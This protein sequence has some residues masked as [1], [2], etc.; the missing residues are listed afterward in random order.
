MSRGID[1]LVERQVLRWLEEQRVS[2]RP[3]EP[4][5]VEASRPVICVSREFGS[6][7]GELG[8]IVAERLEF[9]FYGQELVDEIAR[10]AHVR[11]KVVESLDER[12]QSGIRQWVDQLMVVRRFAQSDYLR[13]LSQVV[14]T[15]GRHGRS[16]VIGRGAHLILDPASTLRVRC[17]APADWRIG[18]VAVRHN[19]GRSD[20]QA[21]MERVDAERAAFYRATFNADVSDPEHFDLLMNVSTTSLETCAEIVAQAFV[22][23]FANVS[24]PPKSQ[25]RATALAAEPAAA[26]RG[27]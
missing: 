17:Y 24:A 6:L 8:R 2:L 27:R 25:V 5:R 23:R 18:Q 21:L 12:V 15:L 26:A 7:G 20:A 16:V 19:L 9:S 1:Q 14:L 11:R 10:Q 13:N 3:P 22:A 4:M